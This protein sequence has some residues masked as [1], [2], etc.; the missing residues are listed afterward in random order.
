MHYS[1]II[2]D[3]E[4]NIREGLANFIDWRSMGF[5]VAATLEDGRDA[6][7][8][9]KKNPVDVVLSD[10]KMNHVSGLEVAKYVCENHPFTKVAILSGYKEFEFAKQAM[11]FHVMHYLLKPTQLEEI[12]KTF[13]EIKLQLDKAKDDR[14]YAERERQQYREILPLL[15]EQF[16]SDLLMGALGNR[17]EL[18]KRAALLELG[19][20]PDD[21]GC[22]MAEIVIK[23]YNGYLDQ[24]WEYGRDGL[25]AAIRNFLQI[26]RAGVSYFPVYKTGDTIPVLAIAM[27][28]M[29]EDSLRRTVEECF[30]EAATGMKTILGLDVDVGINDIYTSIYS[31]A[32]SRKAVTPLRRNLGNRLEDGLDTM[33]LKKLI[34]QQKLFVTLVSEGDG[35]AAVN[36]FNQVLDEIQ[37]LDAELIVHFTRS[38]FNLLY[39]KLSELGLQWNIQLSELNERSPG[40]TDEARRWAVQMIKKAGEY[41]D[42]NKGVSECNAVQKAKEYIR[43]NF[44]KDLSLEEV[45]DS[46]YLSPVYFSRMFKQQTGE[47]FTDYLIKVKMENAILLLKQP[48]NKVY[49]VSSRVGYKSIKYFYK[50]FK[51]YTGFTPTEYRLNLMKEKDE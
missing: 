2:V 19:F 40:S 17:D 23:N 4:R 48:E 1:M 44:Y 16:F 9:I 49:E 27:D 18:R 8:F 3:D 36:L 43:E 15:R 37:C 38:L 29:E 7:D 13:S 31:L 6:I 34:E 45:A 25:Y 35:N 5:R 14:E 24:S 30:R 46:V 11:N 32:R 28:R 12:R 51:K 42:A 33:D 20:D 10:I 22:C 26:Q 21:A 39:G 47:N 50:L 41:M